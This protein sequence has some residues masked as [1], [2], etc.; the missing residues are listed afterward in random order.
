VEYIEVEVDLA[1]GE[2]KGFQ[3][4]ERSRWVTT[5]FFVAFNSFF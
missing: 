5:F 1:I 2:D 3:W 4:E